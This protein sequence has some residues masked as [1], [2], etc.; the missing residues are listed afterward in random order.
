[1]K[2]KLIILALFFSSCQV[3]ANYT[4]DSLSYE[5]F[6]LEIMS[7]LTRYPRPKWWLAALAIHKD[8]QWCYEDPRM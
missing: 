3:L 2:I 1:M 7:Y 5:Y 8:D 4:A 6:K